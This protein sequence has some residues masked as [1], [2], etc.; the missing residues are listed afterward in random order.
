[1][2]FSGLDN[3]AVRLAE[4]PIAESERILQSSSPRSRSGD[5]W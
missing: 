4:K 3:L 5:L 1:M 2:P